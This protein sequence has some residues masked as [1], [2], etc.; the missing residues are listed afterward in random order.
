[1][2]QACGEQ[3]G[4]DRV[5]VSRAEASGAGESTSPC[6]FAL[7]VSVAAVSGLTLIDEKPR[8]WL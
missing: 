1:M 4:G 7:G 5:G 6:A 8:D 2:P 3:V